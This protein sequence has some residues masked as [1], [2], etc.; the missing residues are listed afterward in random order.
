MEH[1]HPHLRLAASLILAAGLASACS[2]GGSGSGTAMTPDP[3]PDPMPV[4]PTTT[5]MPADCTASSATCTVTQTAADGTVTTTVTT[6]MADATAMTNTRT[7]TVGSARTITVTSTATGH[8]NRVNTI[9][10]CTVSGDSCT[11]TRL[12]TRTYT[13]AGGNTAATTVTSTYMMGRE[14]QRVTVMGDTTT[15]VGI[16]YSSSNGGRTETTMVS[17]GT[18]VETFSEFSGGNPT[19]VTHTSTDGRTVTVTDRMGTEATADDVRTV[20]VYTDSGRTTTMSVTTNAGAA[21]TATVPS[22]AT[23]FGAGTTAQTVY[24]ANPAAVAGR[25]L[26]A[27]TQTVTIAAEGADPTPPVITS[28]TY[29]TTDAMGRETTRRTL[30]VNNG[31]DAAAATVTVTTTYPEAGGT[32]ATTVD[33]TAGSERWTQVT[34]SAM[35]T[36][37]TDVRAGTTNAADL[38]TRTVA[39]PAASDGSRTVDT[40]FGPA[41]P[42]ADRRTGG[43]RD[44]VKTNADRTTVTTRFTGAGVTDTDEA[45][46][47]TVSV[48]TRDEN[49]VET[50]LVAYSGNTRTTTTTA[51][52]P[53]GSSTVTTVTASR[54]DADSAYATT[55]TVVVTNDR[56]GRRVLSVTT[57]SDGDEIDRRVTT[58]AADGSTRTETRYFYDEGQSAATDKLQNVGV[59]QSEWDAENSEWDI[60]DD[61]VVHPRAQTHD[62]VSDAQYQAIQTGMAARE[63]AR[64]V[65]G[66]PVLHLNYTNDEAFNDLV[67]AGSRP[68]TGG[69]DLEVELIGGAPSCATDGSC[70]MPYFVWE[71]EP[72]RRPEFR[73]YTTGTKTVLAALPRGQ[74]GKYFGSWGFHQNRAGEGVLVKILADLLTVGGAGASATSMPETASDP[75]DQDETGMTGATVTIKPEATTALERNTFTY[76]K[77]PDTSADL[78]RGVLG[79]GQQVKEVDSYLRLGGSRSSNPVNPV[80]V[81]VENYFGWMANSMF[82]VRRVTAQGVTGDDYDWVSGSDNPG[83]TDEVRAYVGMA[84]GDPSNRP[85]ERRAAGMVDRGIWTGA[86]IGVGSIRGERYRGAAK[87]TVDFNNNEVTTAFSQVRLALESP[88][89]LSENPIRFSE[90]SP[91]L[92]RETSFGFSS[93]EISSTGGYTSSTITGTFAEMAGHGRPSYLSAQFYGPEAAEVAGTFNAHGLALAKE[94]RTLPVIAD[95][96]APTPSEIEAQAALRGDIIGAFGA[97]R[98]PLEEVESN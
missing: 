35:G 40:V 56:M 95:R 55:R 44:R 72:N 30:A 59:V 74:G 77:T 79:I 76:L 71:I 38:I 49:G 87:V 3:D 82:T 13:D 25:T 21:N 24:V 78:P 94:G 41:A 86:M 31:V 47:T 50:M 10:A 89:D 48:S 16:A 80:E 98:D 36:V 60:T 12:E 90:V 52:M 97:T 11:R 92:S 22:A 27:W 51:Y 81:K 67:V 34:T 85:T 2:G 70:T 88:S 83:A 75:N 33:E 96:T 9:E 58:Y 42:A 37:T 29:I 15:T 23:G 5:R 28:R 69:V 73:L 26:V 20:T 8:D 7:V 6:N 32:V 61:I 91:A 4:E 63:N 14:T 84:S 19:S 53:A 46:W 39:N 18:K 17:G 66:L 57:D 43:H 54:A 62:I 1:M 45:D 65:M 64:T 93:D 68:G